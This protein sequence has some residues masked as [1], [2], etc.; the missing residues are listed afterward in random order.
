[1]AEGNTTVENKCAVLTSTLIML[2]RKLSLIRTTSTAL[3]AVELR[4]MIVETRLAV[5]DNYIMAKNCAAEI[6]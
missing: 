2:P 6:R 5:T 4:P 1:M 3:A